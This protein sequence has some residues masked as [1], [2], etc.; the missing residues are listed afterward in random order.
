MP[1]CLNDNI[2][3][4]ATP[5]V[6]GIVYTRLIIFMTLFSALFAGYFFQRV[7]SNWLDDINSA[8]DKNLQKK[9]RSDERGAGASTKFETNQVAILRIPYSV[10]HFNT[11]RYSGSKNK[12]DEFKLVSNI[13]FISK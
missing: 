9:F 5:G 7:N 12:V 10:R 1:V 6:Y 11:F 4:I 2:R 3:E 13:P 8:P